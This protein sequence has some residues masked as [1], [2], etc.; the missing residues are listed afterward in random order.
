MI[1]IL[2]LDQAE[3]RWV[4][5]EFHGIDCHRFA[6]AH[7][8]GPILKPDKIEFFDDDGR[9]VYIVRWSGNIMFKAEV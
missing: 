9:F 3:N 2:D 5:N 8:Y 6:V 7:I 4:L 1:E